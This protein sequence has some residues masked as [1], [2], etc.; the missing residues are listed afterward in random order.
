MNVPGAVQF[1]RGYI[2]GRGLDGYADSI[3]EQTSPEGLRHLA[4]LIIRW[5]M[6]DKH[7]VD[8]WYAL[9]SL[10][11]VELRRALGACPCCRLI[12]WAGDE[13]RCPY[14]GD[15]VCGRCVRMFKGAVMCGRCAR[16][17]RPTIWTRIKNAWGRL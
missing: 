17:L 11:L 13:V 14:C 16:R 10:G 2:A 1:L 15:L 8:L 6:D 7:R 9:S 4:E 3:T 12:L 5:E